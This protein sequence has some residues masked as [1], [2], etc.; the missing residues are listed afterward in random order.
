MAT[1]HQRKAQHGTS[2]QEKGPGEKG[3]KAGIYK[4][5][6]S[7]GSTEKFRQTEKSPIAGCKSF[8][9]SSPSF[10]ARKE[11]RHGHTATSAGRH[12]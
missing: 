4:N 10:L 11:R 1:P 9:A 3:G 2:E 12:R 5:R 8:C 7:L 6:Q